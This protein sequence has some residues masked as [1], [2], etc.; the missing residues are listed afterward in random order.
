MQRHLY[1]S[2]L[3]NMMYMEALHCSLLDRQRPVDKYRL[4][5]EVQ[6]RR[7]EKLRSLNRSEVPE[8]IHKTQQ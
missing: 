8:D 1:L 3:D 2:W 7:K 5:K 6:D 4:V